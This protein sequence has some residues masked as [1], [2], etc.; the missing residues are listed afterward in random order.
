MKADM[1]LRK[2]TPLTLLP[3]SHGLA[4]AGLA[5]S[6]GAHAADEAKPAADV[7]T[8]EPVSVSAQ[9]GAYRKEKNTASAVAPTQASLT[10]TQ[11]QSVITREFIEQSVAPTAE[12]SRIVAIAPSVSGDSANGPG[13]SETKTTLRGFSD[14]QYNITFDGIPWGDTN[15]PAHHSTSFFPGAVIGGAVVERGPGNASNLG[16]ATFG[17]S[18]NLFSK[19]AGK[20]A[21]GSL[22]TSFGRWNTKLLGAALESGELA[23]FH[24]ATVQLNVQRLESDG[25]LTGNSLASTNV[26]LKV[27]VPLSPE[28]TLTGFTSVNR[29]HYVQPDNNKGPT[30]AQVAQ[31]GKN[32]SLNDD[33]TSFNYV[34]FNHT[35]KATRPSRPPTR[36]ARPR[37]A[38]RPAPRATATSPASTSRTNTASWAASSARRASSRPARCAPAS[39]ARTPT[40][41]A[42]STTS[43]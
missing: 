41:T 39:G 43:T 12:Y 25:Y 36:P 24:K 6:L 3:L 5:L 21:G 28:H 1:L 30:L 23:Q 14:D 11:P 29:I 35:T 8:L 32:Y 9:S 38:P 7:V 34:G 33:P 18:L 10:A 27:E 20:Q 22:F 17:G 4:L 42:T 37:P 26:T 2:T 19:Q 40:P 31:Y 16:F 13:L 15:N